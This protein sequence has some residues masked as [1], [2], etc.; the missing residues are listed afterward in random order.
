MIAL[1]MNVSGHLQTVFVVLPS[2]FVVRL[3]PAVLS[4]FVV[5]FGGLIQWYLRPFDRIASLATVL[6]PQPEGPTRAR[7]SPDAIR[8]SRSSRVQ[9]MLLG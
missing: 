5:P 6:F 3:V 2:E 4:T 9:F 7:L 1:A 8:K